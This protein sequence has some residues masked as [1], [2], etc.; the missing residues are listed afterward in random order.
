MTIRRHCRLRSFFPFG[1]PGFR[2]GSLFLDA[3]IAPG[4]CMYDYLI[5][6]VTAKT[7]THMVVE[8]NGIGYFVNIS[9]NTYAKVSEG[10]QQKVYVHFFVK[11]DAHTL[12][13]F[14]DESERRL[15][16]Q[17]ISVTG[18]GPATARMALS[19]LSPDELEHAIVT[20]DTPVIQ[21][22][23]GIGAKSAQRIIIDL[24]DRIRRPEGIPVPGAVPA[25]GMRQEALSVLITLGFAKGVAEKSVDAAIRKGGGDQGVEDLI[26]AAL[27]T[28]G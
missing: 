28:I 10:R 17:L 13:G 2:P 15:F 1:E 16:R 22:I 21:A 14:A 4:S 23:K 25:A 3:G 27:N 11:E 19:S 18:V 9:L 7:A 6:T 12:Y 26:K 24:K 5:G 8:C 20:G